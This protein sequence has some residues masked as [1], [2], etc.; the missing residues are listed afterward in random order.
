MGRRE[1]G[2]SGADSQGIHECGNILSLAFCDNIMLPWWLPNITNYPSFFIFF[3]CFSALSL[4]MFFVPLNSLHFP[5]NWALLPPF[6]IRWVCIQVS[7]SALLMLKMWSWFCYYHKLSVVI[8]CDAFFDLGNWSFLCSKV[9]KQ[10][11]WLV[12]FRWDMF[13]LASKSSWC[14]LSEILVMLHTHTKICVGF[15]WCFKLD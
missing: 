2:S 4:S 13:P 3:I 9:N 6:L 15:D 7:D 1:R 5:T 10:V 8:G 14:F 12:W 11:C